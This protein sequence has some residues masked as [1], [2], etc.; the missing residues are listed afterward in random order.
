M[1]KDIFHSNEKAKP[2]DKTISVLKKHFP[3]CF[4]RDGTFD[5]ER[6]KEFLSDKTSITSEGYELR[7]LG[8]SYARLLASL[9]TTTVIRP[10]EEHNLKPENAASEN[11]YISGDNLDGLKHLLKSYSGKVKCI[12]ID[13]PY[14]TGTDDFVYNDKFDFTVQDLTDKLSISEEQ[15][16]RILDLTKRG[17]A[18]HSAWLMFMYSRLLLARDLLRD[19]GV[20]FISID[21]NECHNLK[22]LCD[23]VFGEEN[24]AASIAW[25][26]RTSIQNDTDF[27]INHEYILAYARIR[28]QSD[29]RLKDDNKSTWF[30]LKSFVFQPIPLDKSRFSNPD[31]DPRGLWKGDPFDAP[32]ERE[33]LSYGIQNPNTGEVFFPASGRHWSTEEENYKRLLADNRI[34]FGQN[35]NARPQ[36]KVFYEEKKEFGS[37]DNSWFMGSDVG[38]ATSATKEQQRLFDGKSYFDT[39]KP[40]GLIE[41]LIQLAIPDRD[42]S[43]VLDFFSGSA[44][45][46]EAV[47]RRNLQRENSNLKYICVQISDEIEMD[48]D[49]TTA[50][51]RKK[52]QKTIDFLDS[53]NR[54]HTIDQ[55]GI[56]RIIRAAKAIR[57]E[58]PDTT[59]DLGF[60]LYTLVEPTNDTIDKLER[61]DPDENKLFA[62]KTLLDDFGKS[63]ILTTW[64]VRDGY[65]LTANTNEM[66]FAGYNGYYIDKHLYLIDPELTGKAI[67]AIV[68]KYE[69]DGDFNPENV[70]LFGYSFTWTQLES[71]ETNLKR[72]KDADKNLRIN[73]A[74]RY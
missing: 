40:T 12:Y 60:K 68:E 25:Q 61:F 27:S 34:F 32:E 26:S 6:F 38:T 53:V 36:L 11:V 49:K 10:N 14:N 28:R 31:N 69:N 7:F 59:A 52:R 70:V 9:D 55:I 1:I 23:D 3:S 51:Q 33:N 64:L 41:K 37:I 43:I 24:F 22:I 56:E 63:T 19:D 50:N 4:N 57:E 15:A 8:K 47:M 45:T 2:T 42:D 73:F 16:K 18:S 21:D 65:G 39:P 44:T 72:L 30:N 66:N 35:G 48:T 74:V 20:M 62:D 54:P 46:A 71:L 13:P 29:I 5:L 58:H 67:G 17:S